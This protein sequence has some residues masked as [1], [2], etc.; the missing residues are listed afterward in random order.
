MKIN[1]MNIVALR[2]LQGWSQEDLAAAAGISVR[3]VQRIETEGKGG[4]ESA[5]A[6]AAAFDVRID[7]VYEPYITLRELFKVMFKTLWPVIIAVAVIGT[8]LLLALHYKFIG[9]PEAAFYAGWMGMAMT[10]MW[11]ATFLW[12]LFKK[13]GAYSFEK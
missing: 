13:Y 10:G 1:K 3:T 8:A 9:E 4:M 7:K 12:E 5:K 11:V 2:N 6:I